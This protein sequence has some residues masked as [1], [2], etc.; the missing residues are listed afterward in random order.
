VLVRAHS[1]SQRDEGFTLI[2]LLVVMIIIGILAGIAIP[3]FLNQRR[4]GFD[5]TAK[6]DIRNAALAE[7][8][9]LGKNGQYA[10]IAT[11]AATEN[12]SI[13]KGTTVVSVF[14]NGEKGFCL[15]SFHT[16]GSPLPASQ[17]SLTGLAP[18]VVWWYDSA[19]GG[20]Q[21]ANAALDPSAYG[22]TKTNPSSGAS[23][24]YT[25]VSR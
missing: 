19:A 10:D 21:P 4:K 5:A 2:E 14:V 8:T 20:L 23:F 25:N 18:A 13:S 3:V 16:G 24:S 1:A 9:Y 15:G 6:S 17:A 22:C 12:V 7:E 11:V